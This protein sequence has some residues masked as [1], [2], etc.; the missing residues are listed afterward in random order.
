MTPLFVN[1]VFDRVNWTSAACVR[2]KHV[3]LTAAFDRYRHS[4]F[5]KPGSDG[6]RRASLEVGE[7]RGGRCTLP[8]CRQSLASWTM[9]VSLV[10]NLDEVIDESTDSAP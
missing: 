5:A 6:S 9:L 3:M 7:S 10:L 8:R 2:R 4:H 1:A